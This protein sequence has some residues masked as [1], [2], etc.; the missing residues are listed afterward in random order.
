MNK[1][2]HSLRTTG[3]QIKRVKGDGNCYFR[4]ISHQLFNSEEKHYSVRSTLVRFENHNRSLFSQYLMD[5]NEATIDDHIQKMDRISVWATQ[6]EVHV[7]ATSSFFQVPVYMLCYTSPTEFHWE[8]VRPTNKDKLRF[9][10]LVDRIEDFAQPAN[11]LTHFEL[12]YQ[13]STHYDSIIDVESGTPSDTV[14]RLTPRKPLSDTT[15]SITIS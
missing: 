6:V 15:N 8:V 13:E 10:V 2:E 9:P 3:R 11:S 5:N 1:L 14:P 4:R 12:A 7:H